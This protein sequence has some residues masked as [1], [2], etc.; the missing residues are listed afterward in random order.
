M[1]A[2]PKKQYVERYQ[3][4]N[5]V[6]NEIELYFQRKKDVRMEDLKALLV[7]ISFLTILLLAILKLFDFV[8]DF[9]LWVSA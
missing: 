2:K 7:A 3:I 6:R 9:Y 4:E 5:Y 8:V 1:S